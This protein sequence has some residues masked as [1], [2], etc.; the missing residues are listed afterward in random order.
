MN[1]ADTFF[2]RG[3]NLMNSRD[4]V[5]AAL[6]FSNPDRPPRD[7]W[8]LP[9]ILL[10]RQ[11]ELQAIQ[12]SYPMD[13]LAVDRYPDSYDN[14]IRNASKIGPYTDD[15]GSVWHVGEIGVSGE[16]KQPVLADWS[17]LATFQPPWHTVRNQ[18]TDYINRT[19]ASTDKFTLSGRTIRPFERMQFL[20][21]TEALYYDIGYDSAEFRSLLEIV[22][23]YYLEDVAG[24]CKTDVDG[25]GMMDDWGSNRNLLINPKSWR[26]FFKPLYKA[27]C[28]MIHAAGKF[29]FFH[30]DGNISSIYADL[31]EIGV[32]AINSQLFVMDIEELARRY[33][34][35]I[36]FWGEIDRQRV[37]PFG[38]PED[39]KDAVMRVR[40]AL[41]DGTGGVIAQCEWGKDNSKEN[42][43]AVFQSWA[44]PIKP[45]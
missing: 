18:D 10:F 14:Y 15:W 33:K 38:T 22:H 2:K 45:V 8:K 36:T 32:D 13:I 31:I 21:G 30:S 29:A 42:V 11:D 35:E 44:E 41:D 34:G 1:H 20:R 12:E 19:C 26:A 6:T 27:Y 9:Y 39:V 16:V 5:I 7:L 3:I 17:A 24:W 28:D 43:E 25:I 23:D 4:R 40:R 37:L